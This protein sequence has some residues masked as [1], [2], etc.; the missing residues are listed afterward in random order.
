MTVSTAVTDPVPSLRRLPVIN[1]EPP[2]DDE[3][4]ARA[5]VVVGFPA[6]AAH[7]ARNIDRQTALAL[8]FALPSGVPATPPS[9]VL[10][11]ARSRRLHVVPATNEPTPALLRRRGARTDDIEFGPQATPRA[12]LPDPTQWATRIS[13]AIVEITAGVRPIAQLVR[14]T[15]CDVYEALQRRVI[16]AAQESRA[17]A[18]GRRRAAVVR[19]VH[20]S[21]PVDGVAEVCAVVQHGSRCRA[22][23]LRL[24]GVDGRWQCTALQVG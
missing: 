1:T 11:P 19:S 8:A 4:D 2:F 13:Q 21:E 3:I 14:W 24:E 7:S 9:R 16:R 15:N 23:A 12:L 22:L 6:L 10:G 18:S 17:A 20:V 5:D